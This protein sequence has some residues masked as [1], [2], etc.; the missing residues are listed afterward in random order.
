MAT[1]RQYRNERKP[2]PSERSGA[3]GETEG[4]RQDSG[5]KQR[6]NSHTPCADTSGEPAQDG[7]AR[8]DAGGVR[9]DDPADSCRGAVL[10]GETDDLE[11]QEHEAN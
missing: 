10:A 3:G 7:C 5:G 8:G 6:Q 9:G 11:G 1:L 2:Q 4:D